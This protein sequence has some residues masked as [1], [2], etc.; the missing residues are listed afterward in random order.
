M[1]RRGSRRP[2]GGRL[3]M[4]FGSGGG[5]ALAWTLERIGRLRAE[6][7]AAPD[8]PLVRLDH[9]ARAG[10]ALFLKD[11]TR[12]PSG[13][14]KHRLARSLFL[15]ALCNQWLKPGRPAVDASSGSTAISEAWFARLL[16]V[17][18]VAVLPAATAPAKL[19]ELTALGARCERVADPADIHARAAAIAEQTGGCYLDQFTFAERATDW[20]GNNNIAESILAQLDAAGADAPAW[21]VA[22]AGTGGTLATVGRYLRYRG[23]ATRLCLADPEGSVLAQAWASGDH[24]ARC[25]CTSVI[26]GIG[27]PRVEPSFMPALIDR[28]TTVPDAASLAAMLWLAEVTGT[29]YGGSSGTHVYAALALA[30][31]GQ[32]RGPIVS[33][34]GDGGER[35]AETLYDPAWVADRGLDP[36]PWLAHLRRFWREG[37]WDPPQTVRA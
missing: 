32:G 10:A 13:S 28:A 15:Y 27:R 30:A 34:L 22:G 25:R 1:E 37:V 19:A 23:L 9:P 24:S 16:E 17:P 4:A 5:D 6:A 33:V 26:E 21:F 18:Y 14:L 36:G 3:S 31:S 7:A 20:R 12:H 2:S 11:E 8:T 35:Y 29:R